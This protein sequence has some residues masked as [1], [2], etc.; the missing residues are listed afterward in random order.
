MTSDRLT[1]DQITTLISLIIADG[2]AHGYGT[3][4]HNDNCSQ[5]PSRLKR[6]ASIANK[7]RALPEYSS[8]QYVPAG[9]VIISVWCINDHL[10]AEYT[11][12]IEEKYP[13]FCAECGTKFG[14]GDVRTGKY[15]WRITTR[16]EA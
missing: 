4:Y 3:R 9:T 1:R 5:W 7:L 14:D 16:I 15:P 10:I 2:K 12:T 11:G 8:L 13:F 6:L